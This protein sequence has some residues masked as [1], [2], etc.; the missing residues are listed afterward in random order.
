MTPF[1]SD[2]RLVETREK[3]GVIPGVHHPICFDSLRKHQNWYET[4]IDK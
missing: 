3:T 4:S 2:M 1:S